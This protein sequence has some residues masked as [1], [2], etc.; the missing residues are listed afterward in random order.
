MTREWLKCVTSE[1]FD[2]LTIFS[3][4]SEYDKVRDASTSS[5]S[6]SCSGTNNSRDSGC[7]EE[8]KEV[9]HPGFPLV[10]LHAANKIRNRIEDYKNNIIN[11]LVIWKPKKV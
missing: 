10:S 3:T 4:N 2:L 7:Q 1:E 8:D 11:S 6:T 9:F 5:T